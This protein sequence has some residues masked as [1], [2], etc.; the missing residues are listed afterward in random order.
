MPR[1]RHVDPAGTAQVIQIA[2]SHLG[3]T[4]A[5]ELFLMPHRRYICLKVRPQLSSDPCSNRTSYNEASIAYIV[6]RMARQ[7]CTKCAHSGG[8]LA[9][10]VFA[11]NLTGEKYFGGACT[12]CRHRDHPKECSFFQAA[13]NQGGGS[14]GY[15]DSENDDDDEIGDEDYGQLPEQV[16]EDNSGD[17][18]GTPPPSRRRRARNNPRQYVGGK[19]F[20]QG[21][22]RQEE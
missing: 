3:S 20:Q 19:L 9:E 7:K 1:I 14:D 4:V 8:R 22:F 11:H 5:R 21:H 2:Q 17:Y 12:N 6:G 13:G 15:D 10:C 18:R 16:D